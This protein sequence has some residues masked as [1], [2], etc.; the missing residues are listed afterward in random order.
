MADAL[1]SAAVFDPLNGVELDAQVEAACAFVAAEALALLAQIPP[2]PA[3]VEPVEPHLEDEADGHL[4]DAMQE[5]QSVLAIEAGLLYLIGGYDVN[6]VALVRDL[7]SLGQRQLQT[8][9]D[10]R[11]HNAEV[12]RERLKDF[13]SGRVGTDLAGQPTTLNGGPEPIYSNLVEEVR[14][15]I[16]HHLA[17]A[18]A[19][20][21]AWLGGE[22]DD[23]RV[24]AREI[25]EK[26]RR[27][28]APQARFPSVEFADMHHLASLMG[29]AFDRTATRSVA[30]VLPQ[31]PTQDAGFL[32]QFANYI[33]RRV[34][35]TAKHHGRPFLWPSAME[36]V[37]QCLPGPF[38]DAVIAMPTGSGKGFVAELAIVHAL[39]NGN[40]LYLAPTNALVHQIRRDIQ[41]A[42]Q[43]FEN[44]QVL[45]FIGSGEYTGLEEEGFGVAQGRFVAVMTPEK[46]ALALRLNPEVVATCSLCVFDECHLLNDEQ[47]GITADVLMAQLFHRAPAMR[48]VLMSAMVSNPDQLADWLHTARG[49]DARPSVTKWRPTRTLRGMLVADR[50]GLQPPFQIARTAL[51]D[52]RK[53]QPHRKNMPF[54]APLGLVAGLSGPWALGAGGE[55]YR[56]A[57]VGAGIEAKATV[58][59]AGIVPEIAT[60]WKNP[61]TRILA[62]RLSSM[63]IPTI[64]FILT[65]RHH[66]FG[67]AKS[68]TSELPGHV[69]HGAP[70]PAVIEA[71]LAIADAELG[72]QTELRSLLRKGI[73]VH[74][75]AMLQV[76]QAAAEHMFQGGHAKLMFATGTLAQGL[77]L[78]ALAV[79][80]GGTTMGDPRDADRI[81]GLGSR[82]DAAILNAFG[83][84]GRPSY[85]NQGMA[86]LVPDNPVSATVGHP[87][88]SDAALQA[89]S[90][91]TK[92]DAGVNIGSPIINFFDRMLVDGAPLPAATPFELS[93]TAQLAEQPIDGDHAGEVLRRTFGGYLRRNLFTPQVSIQ[94]R[95]RLAFVKAEFL[96]QPG[97]P[98]WMNTAA[99]Q[100]GVDIFRA[101][102]IWAALEQHGVVAREQ[103]EAVGVPAW[104]AVLFDT[105]Q[106]L[107]PKYLTEYS[108]DNQTPTVLT[109]LRESALAHLAVDQIP[110]PSP[111]IWA[112]QWNELHGLVGAYMSGASYAALGRAYYGA[113]NIPEPFPTARTTSPNPY[114]NPLPGV[115]GF[116][117]EIVDPLARDAG[118]LVAILEQSWKA[119]GAAAPPQALQA[120]PLCLRFGCNSLE[121]LAWYRFGFPQRVSAH[122]L[123]RAFPLPVDAASDSQRATE[124]RQLRRRWLAGQIAAAVDNPILENVA[125]VLREAGD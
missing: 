77:N 43:P 60:S 61:A 88:P 31:P 25:V 113:E 54:E 67:L 40:I 96:Q 21:L 29:A 59:P 97:I 104:L 82:V 32:S 119:Q 17:S 30:H 42:L 14:T 13:C 28:T 75:S 100:A 65:S 53:T 11:L 64:G 95:D 18:L 22:S 70:M 81:P 34:R 83:R 111:A 114:N 93:L 8:L 69:P 109:R 92:P 47:R 121:T 118:C 20:F 15:W 98:V 5:I 46:C 90:V 16:Y 73:S 48:F 123:A 125:T 23:R 99:T 1:E 84:A 68:V 120:L 55:D 41:Y 57:P 37:E 49:L 89:S 38:R 7:P 27:A 79:V 36:Y 52:L 74:T 44:V 6:A 3:V 107:P 105:I 103:A 2:T 26:V 39:S 62:E 56:F 80:V 51:E 86:V 33:K 115:F 106:R 112:E 94:I 12:L 10:A 4:V 66:P 101:S 76:E 35:G 24:R 63:G 78:P 58:K 45:A 110:W 50:D 87:K 19:E 102:K 117:R 85:S 116:I 124:A 9:R 91:L 122:A 108:S 71:W 72:V